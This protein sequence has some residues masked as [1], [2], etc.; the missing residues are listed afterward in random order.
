MAEHE[1]EQPG[2]EPLRLPGTELRLT[3]R[4][5][6]V[7]GFFTTSEWIPPVDERTRPSATADG[8][9]GDPSSDG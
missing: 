6:E 7:S 4:P 1:D 5:H 2:S 8:D 3:G 9:P